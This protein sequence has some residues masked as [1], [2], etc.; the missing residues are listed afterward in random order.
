MRLKRY[1]QSSLPSQ[2]VSS[3]GRWRT[4]GLTHS[5]VGMSRLGAVVLTAVAAAD[6]LCGAALVCASARQTDQSR[7]ARSTIRKLRNMVSSLAFIAQNYW[8]QPPAD[9]EFPWRF[10]YVPASFVIL[11][12]IPAWAAI[13]I[14]FLRFPLLIFGNCHRMPG[15]AQ[16]LR[17]P[18]CL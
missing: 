10:P 9:K 15:E 11:I 13:R 3:R 17:Q 6:A 12:A 7:I 5:G 8:P 16:L 4:T 1:F 18:R 14:L 2:R